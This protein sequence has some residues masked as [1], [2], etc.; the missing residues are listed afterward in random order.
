MA[1]RKGRKARPPLTGEAL[2]ELAL[3]YVG[4]FATTRSKLASYLARKLR[5]RGWAGEGAADV[6]AVVERLASLGYVDDAAFALSKSRALTGRGYGVRR[7]HQALRAAGVEEEDSQ[8]ARELAEAES[9]EAALRFA[10]RRR[11]GPFGGGCGDRSERER[12]LAAMIRAGH[13][14]ALSRSILSLEPGSEVDV[15]SLSEKA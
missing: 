14:F 7:V 4:R 9:V 10:R 8:A 1:R 2:N 12:A 5:E 13:P 3:A 15:E 11:L 6:A